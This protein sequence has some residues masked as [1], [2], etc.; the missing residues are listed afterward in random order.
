MQIK[1]K[2]KKSKFPNFQLHVLDFTFIMESTFCMKARTI[3]MQTF[4]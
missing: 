3:S 2:K 1:K 4:E